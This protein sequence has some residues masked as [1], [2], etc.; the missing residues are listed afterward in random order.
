MKSRRT[1]RYRLPGSAH[2]LEHIPVAPDHRTG[3]D[4]AADRTAGIEVFGPAFSAHWAADRRRIPFG[5]E[6]I[7]LERKCAPVTGIHIARDFY[8][9]E[10]SSR[11]RDSLG[12]NDPPVDAHTVASPGDGICRVYAPRP[13]ASRLQRHI[14]GRIGRRELVLHRMVL[15][16]QIMLQ[17]VSRGI[18]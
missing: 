4:A 9:I 15:V 1:K 7:R 5:F 18:V 10:G 17:P 6:Y 11:H 13:R 3:H 12:A 14:V 8:G 2:E 16:G